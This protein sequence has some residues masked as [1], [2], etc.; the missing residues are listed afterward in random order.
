MKRDPD[1]W[2][3]VR[4]PTEELCRLYH[5]ICCQRGCAP[6]SRSTPQVDW[7]RRYRDSQTLLAN[8]RQDLMLCQSALHVEMTR[9]AGAK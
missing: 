3:S 1:A 7:F 4:Q 8:A 2:L 9:K 5:G 6:A